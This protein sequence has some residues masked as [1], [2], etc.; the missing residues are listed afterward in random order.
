MSKKQPIDEGV[1]SLLFR[2]F[3]KATGVDRK[4]LKN[5]V[6]R[7]ELKDIARLASNI[8]TKLEDL[9]KLTGHD[10]SDIKF[11]RR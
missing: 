3:M 2:F 8:N 5:P 7:R 11:K 1:A 6:V 10:Y 4:I 9:E